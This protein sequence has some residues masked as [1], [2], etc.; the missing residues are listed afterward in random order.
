MRTLFDGLPLAANADPVTSHEAAER[1][2]ASGARGRHCRLVLTLVQE[3]P[4]ATA[5][6]LYAVQQELER[7]EVS[8]RLADLRNAGLV[9]QG[10]PRACTVRG[11]RM[12][13]WY[14]VGA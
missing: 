12:V 11:T 10:E 3:N 7:H 4:G 1:H 6:E 13:T 5:V 9:C 14:A 2:T 8:R